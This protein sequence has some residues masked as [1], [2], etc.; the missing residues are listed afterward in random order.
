MKIV[1]L[2]NARSKYNKLIKQRQEM[3]EYKEKLA[4]LRRK[5]DTRGY[6]KLLQIIDSNYKAPNEC[7]LIQEAFSEVNFKE[8]NNNIMVFVGSYEYYIDEN[9]IKRKRVTNEDNPNASFKAY[10]NLETGESCCIGLNEC[11]QFERNHLTLY[12][13]VGEC[14]AKEY[15]YAYFNLRK[16]YLKDLISYSQSRVIKD[17]SNKY[18]V[19]KY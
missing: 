13:P 6:F 19:Y 9:G 12:I 2:E 8:N 18:K 17:L 15:S 16:K 11:E 5:H 4:E 3:L 10:M 1:E 14:S 7:T